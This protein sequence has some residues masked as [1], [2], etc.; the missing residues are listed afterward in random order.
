MSHDGEIFS[1]VQY[2]SRCACLPLAFQCLVCHPVDSGKS[3]HAQLGSGVVRQNADSCNERVCRRIYI[4]V[5]NVY[6]YISMLFNRFNFPISQRDLI[7]VHNSPFVKVGPR[8]LGFSVLSLEPLLIST[9]HVFCVYLEAYTVYIM[10]LLFVLLL[11][12]SLDIRVLSSR[13]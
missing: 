13:L 7:N 5:Y 6:I 9:L 4:Y 11:L 8:S 2:S 10:L 12:Y 3:E 1:R